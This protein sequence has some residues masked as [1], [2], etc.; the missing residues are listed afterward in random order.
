MV[1]VGLA[2]RGGGITRCEGAGSC[3]ETGRAGRGWLMRGLGEGGER[4][5]LGGDLAQVHDLPIGKYG[6]EFSGYLA[7]R[8]SH[9]DMK[10]GHLRE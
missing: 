2:A 10:E 3:G 1:Q 8:D 4:E 9:L 5:S 6:M 7:L